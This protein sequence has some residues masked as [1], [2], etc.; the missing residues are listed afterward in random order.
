MSAHYS[1]S[2]LCC[3]TFCLGGQIGRSGGTVD[4]PELCA[5]THTHT[6]TTQSETER[7]LYIQI[8]SAPLQPP[9]T[10]PD[11]IVQH[12]GGGGVVS[13]IEELLAR[14]LSVPHLC[15]EREGGVGGGR[16]V[17]R[18]GGRCGR[19]DGYC[20]YRWRGGESPPAPT[21]KPSSLSSLSAP[22]GLERS[23]KVAGLVRSAEN[24]R[25]F[26][27]DIS[28]SRPPAGP[29]PA[30]PH[31]LAYSHHCTHTSVSPSTLL[32]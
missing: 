13:A 32:L 16:E 3:G 14:T 29:P 9:L 20:R 24:K 2:L 17:W 21:L 31:T 27:L 18:E 28:F 30:A 5:H 19:S 1:M 23:R 25:Q 22:I 12:K 8:V 10:C 4:T 6:H 7:E 26:C 11:Q 15:C